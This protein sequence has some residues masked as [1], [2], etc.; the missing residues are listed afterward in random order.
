MVTE[1]CK[2]NEAAGCPVLE[3]AESASKSCRNSSNRL[4]RRPVDSATCPPSWP[5]PSPQLPPPSFCSVLFCSVLFCSVLFCSVL[6]C[7]VLFCSVL[8]LEIPIL[9]RF[10]LP[11]GVKD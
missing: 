10:L 8:L 4:P 9:T 1:S 6:F 5:H 2:Y 3:S 7:S 11:D